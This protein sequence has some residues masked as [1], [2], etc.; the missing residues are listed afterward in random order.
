MFSVNF[1]LNIFYSLLKYIIIYIY[2]FLWQPV[3]SIFMNEFDAVSS[4][5]YI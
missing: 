3:Y 1:I 2:V 5:S 4:I